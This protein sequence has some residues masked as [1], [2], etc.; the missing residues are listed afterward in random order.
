MKILFISIP[1]IHT[2]RW[3][4]NLAGIEHELYWFDVMGRGKIETE[5]NLKQYTHW[6][7]K[8]LPRIKGRT[9]VKKYFPLLYEKIEPYMEI[10]ANEK[11]VQI[12]EEIQPDLIHSFEMQ[13][14]SY[15]ILRTMQ[16]YPNIKWLYS[17]WGSDL[18]YY[19]NQPQHLSNIKAVL[20]RTQYLH[21]DCLRDFTIAKRLGFN[22][23][24]L[25]I[26]PG[27]GGF[28][29]EEFQIYKKSISERKII[30]VKGYEH[31]FGR[32]L[33]VVKALRNIMP[34]QKNYKVV[35][36]GAHKCVEN[37]IQEHNLPFLVYDRNALSH[38]EVLQLMGE[39]IVFIGNSISDGLPNT[40]LEAIV[41]GAF[42]I[43]SNPGG[44][45]EEIIRH[46]ENGL[47]IN[48]PEDIQ[49]IAELIKYALQNP[50]MIECAFPI[51]R[52]IAIQKLGFEINRQK[53]L[54][55][56]HQIE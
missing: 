1:S 7:K 45:S 4:E 18:F 21:T 40:L 37:Y 27:G 42:P 10:T 5:I 6:K 53:I 41:M 12:I 52:D 24:H 47:L 3:I 36:F 48:N 49:E 8:K 29:L 26:I 23:N 2:V 46:G 32:G 31:L 15:P 13:S 33:N 54:T 35:V 50:K 19:Q 34:E 39:S 9:L 30:L 51:N 17:C 55:L 20:H 14:C 43:Q 11:L 16:K 25:G 56:Y 38:K 28:K 44:A 22:G